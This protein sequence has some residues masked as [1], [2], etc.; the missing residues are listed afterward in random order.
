MSTGFPLKT[1]RRITFEYVLMAGVNDSDED[2][3]RLAAL[4]DKIPSKV[5]LISC[6]I[7]SSVLK[8]PAEERTR[9]FQEALLERGIMATLRK[10]RGEI[11][12][13]PLEMFCL[14]NMAGN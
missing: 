5:N 4:L 8:A 13:G 9:A 7:N 3:A 6:N 11:L 2:A 10:S 1:R 12:P 14:L